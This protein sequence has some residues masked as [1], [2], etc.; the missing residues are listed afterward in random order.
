M[1]YVFVMSYKTDNNKIK[2]T[3]DQIIR[4]KF[5]R[6]NYVFVMCH[7]TTSCKIGH[8]LQIGTVIEVPLS[9]LYY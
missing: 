7:Q 3:F 1:K 6:S 8:L 4:D 5:K 9:S 2:K